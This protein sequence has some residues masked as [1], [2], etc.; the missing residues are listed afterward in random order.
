MVK[1]NNQILEWKNLIF[2]KLGALFGLLFLVLVLSFVSPY[3]LT[4]NNLS[5]VLQQASINAL[6][7][8]G[9]LLTILTAGIDLSVG[10]VLAL[11]ISIGG[12]SIINHGINPVIGILIVLLVG[13][14]AGLT[15]GLLLTKLNLPH[16]FISTLGMMNI[17]RGLA[18]IVTG[19]SPVTGFPDWVQFI[20]SGFIGVVP[21][22]FIVVIGVVIFFH[23]FL[24]RTTLGRHIYAV[25]GNLEAA[26]LSGIDTD[27]VLTWV[28]TISGFMAAM[29]GVLLMGKV[30]A[31]YPNA[32]L[33]YELDA[34][35]AVIIGGASFLG[36]VGNIWGTLIGAMILAV[37]RNGLNLIGVSP[38]LQTVVI[39]SVIIVAVYIDVLR[40]KN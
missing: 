35:A 13:V 9:M 40:R 18:I 12:I 5:N 1:D 39:G 3:F 37:I 16:P 14:L 24:N 15:N 11:S 19:A 27:K 31:A 7:A 2:E 26:K 23:F 22:S 17:A 38:D 25:G 20:G 10:S 28:Y 33:M 29:G 4:V 36:G 32:G 8:S 6:V 34:I 30:N 21:V